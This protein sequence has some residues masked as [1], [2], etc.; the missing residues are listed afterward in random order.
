M[1]VIHMQKPAAQ[2]PKEVKKPS[3]PMPEDVK[4]ETVPKADLEAMVYI[5]IRLPSPFSCHRHHTI[6][7]TFDR[8]KSGYG[9]KNK[10]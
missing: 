3:P 2:E 10:C 7:V 6:I 5:A 9:S 8:F 1:V 4:I